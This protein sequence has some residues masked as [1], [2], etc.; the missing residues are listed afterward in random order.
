VVTAH[1]IISLSAASKK[2]LLFLCH[3]LL[4]AFCSASDEQLW[5]ASGRAK[6]CNIENWREAS[7]GFM[8]QFF[9][10]PPVNRSKIHYT[11]SPLFS[12]AANKNGL[13]PKP[14]ALIVKIKNLC[15]TR[16]LEFHIPFGWMHASNTAKLNR[17]KAFNNDCVAK[18]EWANLAM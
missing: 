10:S 11:F 7:V 4:R 6:Q 3:A 12:K 15:E 18:L 8:T 5:T 14:L 17:L 13:A 16:W 2:L 1:S 9:L